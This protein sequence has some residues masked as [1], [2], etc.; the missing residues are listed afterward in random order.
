V[1]Y[2][3]LLVCRDDRLCSS[4][5][6]GKTALITGGDSGLGRSAALMFAI[7]GARGITITYLPEEEED[8][9]EAARD[10]EA[11]GA[12][13]VT[14]KCDLMKNADCEMVVNEHIKAFGTL[15]V[16]VNNAGKQMYV[17]RRLSARTRLIHTLLASVES[18]KRSTSITST[19]PSS[20]TFSRSLSLRS[21]YRSSLTR[22]F[23]T[24]LSQSSPCR[25]SNA[26]LPSST[27][28]MPKFIR[29]L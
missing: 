9:Q 17:C 15:N 27:S 13:V 22:Y 20:R 3:V 7:E 11:H 6:K 14:V 29:S 4:R 5:L 25:I 23:S 2:A 19:A 28:R 8:V 10:I 24:L 18:S 26:A 16:L 12:K 21:S 1:S